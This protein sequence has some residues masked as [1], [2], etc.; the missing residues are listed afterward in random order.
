MINMFDQEFYR[1]YLSVS[2]IGKNIQYYDALIST[3]SKALELASTNVKDGTIIITDKQTSGR[4]RKSNKW[5]S[6]PGKS[7]TFSVILFPK[8]PIDQINYFSLIAGLAVSDALIDL[9][10]APQLKWPNDILINNKKVGG[11][12]CESRLSGDTI[13]S[14]VIG[15][16]LNINEDIDEFPD[17]LKST[18]TTLFSE[19]GRQNKLEIVLAKLLY[20]LEK[21]INLIDSINEQFIEWESLCAHLETKVT[22]H[23]N[24]KIIEGIFKGLS[25]NGEAIVLVDGWKKVFN[26]GELGML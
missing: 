5:F 18:S 4:G 15:I 19:T 24:D 26:S 25:N 11:I 2:Y 12:L 6:V 7:L 9:G 10:I 1:K 8:V 23:N 3:N 21:R 17:Y 16:G 20:N 22:F 14:L 13:N